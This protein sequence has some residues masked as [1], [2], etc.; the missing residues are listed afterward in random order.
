MFVILKQDIV[1][2]LMFFYEIAFKDKGFSLCFRGQKLNVINLSQKHPRSG[3]K[4]TRILKIGAHAVSQ[5][6][7]LA[8]IKNFRP[9]ILHDINSG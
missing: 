1:F 7:G 5:N 9:A 2:R 4:A 3:M 6:F 8:Y